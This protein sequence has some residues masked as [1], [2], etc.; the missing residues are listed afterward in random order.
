MSGGERATAIEPRELADVLLS[1]GR[2]AVT[3]SEAAALLGV[4]ESHVAPLLARQLQRARFFSP[5]KGLYVAIPPEFRS[6]GAVPASHFVDVMM[7]HLGHPYYVCLLSAAELHG[8][9]H[10]RP[11]VFQVMTV[12]R[13]RPRS[14]GRVKVEFVY[15]SMTASRPTTAL[16]TATGTMRVSKLGTTMLD[17]VAFANRSGGLDNV[18]TIFEEMLIAGSVD[19]VDLAESG[20]DYPSSVVQRTGWLLDYLGR[21]SGHAVATEPLLARARERSTPT[22]L[23]PAYGRSGALDRRWNVVVARVPEADAV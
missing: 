3:T 11:Q 18:A 19:T 2:Q 15:S 13:L 10:Q 16:N 14:F 12:A 1:M 7:R 21:R 4:P 17:L 23:E 8:F 9:A 20:A 6:W 22:P 5:T